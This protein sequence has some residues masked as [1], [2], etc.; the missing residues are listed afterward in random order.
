M[1]ATTTEERRMHPLIEEIYSTG[2]VTD[3]QGERVVPFPISIRYG[4]GRAF[5]DLV[6]EADATRTL[7]V[8]FAYGMAGLFLCQAHFERGHGTHVAIDPNQDTDYRSI[9]R[10]NIERAGFSEHFELR[11]APSH[12]ALPELVAEGRE[13][14]FAFIDGMHL[15]DY[16]LVDFY[17][18]DLMLPVGGYIAF[19][20]LWMPAVRKVISFILRNRP[21]EH[22][23]VDTTRGLPLWMR[24]AYVARKVAQNPLDLRDWPMRLSPQGALVLR[25]SGEDRRPWD[26]YKRF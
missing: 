12:T 24:L 20:D 10:L 3:A 22:V 2:E 9:G 7:E 16:A 6:V 19:D 13:V 18:V 25:K 11:Q 17:Y 26:W 1:R 15:F 21:Y 4:M 14:D 23:A 8:G 5:H